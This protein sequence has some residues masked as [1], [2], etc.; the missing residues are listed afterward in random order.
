MIMETKTVVVFDNRVVPPPHTA[1]PT[2]RDES[3]L[4]SRASLPQYSFREHSLQ[5]SLNS[6]DFAAYASSAVALYLC[7]SHST[8]SICFRTHALSPRIVPTSPS[9]PFKSDLLGL[10]NPELPVEWHA[11]T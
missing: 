7:N 3:Y 9:T 10:V 1:S 2:P 6:C 4:P 8:S 11:S 5:E